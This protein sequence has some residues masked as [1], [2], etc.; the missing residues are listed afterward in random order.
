MR[1]VIVTGSFGFVGS[2][3]IFALNKRGVVPYVIDRW[4]DNDPKA[5][6]VKGLLFIRIKEKDIHDPYL[7]SEEPIIVCLGARVDTREKMSEDMWQDNVETPIRLQPLSSKFI[8]TSS[9]SVYGSE[10]SDFTE[11]I[12][13]LKPLNDYATTKFALDTYFFGTGKPL[14]NVYSLRLTNVYGPREIHKGDMASLVTKGLL[15]QPPLYKDNR[16]TLFEHPTGQPIERDFIFADDVANAIIH[17]IEKDDVPA[18]IYNLGSGTSRSFADLVKAVED[19]PIEYVSLPESLR[20]QY[21]RFTKAN[22]TRLREVAGYT[23]LFTS[24][25]EGVEKT[26]QWMKEEGLIS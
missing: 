6:N 3:T 15:K 8:Y 2:N 1:P 5:R 25:E 17:F 19:L 23:A 20:L 22:I 26:R 11:R 7:F 10:E 18:G 13:G 16:W 24:L 21:Q 4:A 9:G 14:D 12:V